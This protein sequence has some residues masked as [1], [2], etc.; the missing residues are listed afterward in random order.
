MI[1]MSS[2]LDKSK[3]LL[4]GLEIKKNQML[5]NLEIS[6]GLIFSEPIMLS[7]GKKLG[8]Q[9]AHDVIYRISMEVFEKGMMFSY[10]T[11]SEINNILDAR[12]Y[13]GLSV[14]RSWMKFL[15]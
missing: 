11:E 12:R 9:K 1:L 7:L 8:R 13:T 10:F 2:L 6:K 5:K 15:P 14:D 3:R 4:S